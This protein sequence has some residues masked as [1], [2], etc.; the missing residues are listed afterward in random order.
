MI[1]V[2]AAIALLAILLQIGGE[3]DLGGDIPRFGLIRC[4]LEFGA[5][6]MLAAYWLKGLPRDGREMKAAFMGSAGLL[7]A[8]ASGPGTEAWTFPAASACLILA[9]AHAS[10]LRRN[11]LHWR[12]LHY[13][14]E[15]SYATYLSHFLLFFAFKL[16]FVRD[17]GNVPPVQAAAYLALVLAASVALYTLVERPAQRAILRRWTRRARRDETMLAP[18]QP[19]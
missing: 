3:T 16:A 4:L 19:G 15:I 13:L 14:G 18:A 6:T 8:W 11:P 10:G 17:A 12:P 5:G 7:L 1:G 2:A 9:L